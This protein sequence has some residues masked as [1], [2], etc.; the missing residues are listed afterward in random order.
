MG[1]FVSPTPCP[2]L[3]PA[4]KEI[5]AHEQR[6]PTNKHNDGLKHFTVSS[7]NPGQPYGGENV[8]TS[9]HQPY[10]E[11]LNGNCPLILSSLL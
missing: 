8:Q 3:V 2:S 7:N 9:L 11:P 1:L 6:K 4:I 5:E 10:H